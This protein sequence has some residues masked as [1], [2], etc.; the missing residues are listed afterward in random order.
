MALKETGLE[1]MGTENPAET[2]TREADGLT[3]DGGFRVEDFPAD[4]GGDNQDSDLS[5]IRLAGKATNS[6]ADEKVNAQMVEMVCLMVSKLA[7]SLTGIEEIGLDDDERKQLVEL[8]KP[9][10]PDMSPLAQAI[11][12]TMMIVSSKTFL[13][14]QLR[15]L[16]ANQA[17]VEG[18]AN[19]ESLQHS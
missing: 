9:F 11:L 8:W 16:R 18:D 2:K 7:V 14:L 4:F 1:K 12:G 10:T 15:K 3:G 17:S 6:E 5:G 19:A 13:Y